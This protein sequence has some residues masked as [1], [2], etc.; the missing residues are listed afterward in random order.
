MGKSF[1]II[2]FVMSLSSILI[3]LSKIFLYIQ[4]I[5]R[6]IGQK[7]TEYRCAGQTKNNCTQCS[8]S[9]EDSRAYYRC[10]YMCYYFNNVKNIKIFLGFIGPVESTYSR[11]TIICFVAVIFVLFIAVMA[12]LLYFFHFVSRLKFNYNNIRSFDT[13]RIS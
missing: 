8:S 1:E 10:F 6:Q 12:G 3:I 9:T 11:Q 7:C 5:Y 4:K 2:Q 13:L